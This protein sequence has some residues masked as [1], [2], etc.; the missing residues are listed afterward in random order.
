MSQID[1][2]IE[3]VNSFLQIAM[4]Q[5]VIDCLQNYLKTLEKKK[6]EQLP[7]PIPSKEENN[8]KDEATPTN[9]SS[10]PLVAPTKSIKFE[11]VND[12]YWEQNEKFVK[13]YIPLEGLEAY[14]NIDDMVKVNFTDSSFDFQITNLNGKNY[15]LIQDNLEKEIDPKASY[16]KKQGS[17]KIVIF[18]AKVKGEFAYENWTQLIAKKSKE[19]KKK[20]KDDPMGGMF[21]IIKNIN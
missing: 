17:K 8:S 14:N 7:K 16:F 10:I 13:V 11:S 9:T 3:E 1:K 18:L 15:R 4:H 21:N 6:Q 2:E 19:D 20:S 5:G 12:F